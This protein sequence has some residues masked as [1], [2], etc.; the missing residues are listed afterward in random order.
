MPCLSSQEAKGIVQNVQDP[1]LV[2]LGPTKMFNVLLQ[3]R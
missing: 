3:A 2:I 1:F